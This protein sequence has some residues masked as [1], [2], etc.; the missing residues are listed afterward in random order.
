MLTAA[1]ASPYVSLAVMIALAGPLVAYVEKKRQ[2]PLLPETAIFHFAAGSSSGKTTLARVAQSVFG[3]PDIETDYEVSD[4]GVAERACQRNNLALIIDD[5]ESA[6]LSDLDTF[7]KI[8][9]LAQ[10]LPRGRSRAI[11]TRSARTDLRRFCSRE[12]GI[13]AAP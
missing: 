2:V 1:A 4:R 9:K 12:R 5:T 3:A 8:Q 7:A 6:E 11:S 13:P 10:H